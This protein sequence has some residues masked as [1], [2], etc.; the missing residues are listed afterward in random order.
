MKRT[1][2]PR[3]AS[4][5]PLTRGHTLLAVTVC[6]LIPAWSWLEGSGWLAWTMYSKS[7][8]YRVQIAVYDAN[9]KS[10][11]MSP[12]ELGAHASRDL[13]IYLSGSERW[14]QA[15]VGATLRRHLSELTALACRVKQPKRVEITLEE[16]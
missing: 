13:L 4:R 8:T 14:R 6:V 5:F 10:T 15:P 1:Q 11:W 3:T 16:R 2:K 7:A 9:G 12:T